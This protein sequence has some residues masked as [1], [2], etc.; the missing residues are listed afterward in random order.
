LQQAEK[1]VDDGIFV[2]LFLAFVFCF[3]KIPRV[4]QSSIARVVFLLGFGLFVLGVWVSGAF[5]RGSPR[6]KTGQWGACD[7][8]MLRYLANTFAASAHPSTVSSRGRP[9]GAFF[10]LFSLLAG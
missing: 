1:V 6:M 4:L 5:V 7:S 3:G 10:V 2:F 9:Q 8:T